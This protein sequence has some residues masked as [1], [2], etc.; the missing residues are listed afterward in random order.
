MCYSYNVAVAIVFRSLVFIVAALCCSQ[1]VS[2]SV[3]DVAIVLI[4]AKIVVV[5]C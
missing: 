2:F 4:V 1:K 3:T 5:L